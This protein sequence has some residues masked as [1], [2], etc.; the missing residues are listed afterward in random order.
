MYNIPKNGTYAGV[1]MNQEVHNE[2]WI[3]YTMWLKLAESFE[4][5]FEYFCFILNISH[6]VQEN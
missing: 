4:S 5:L 2:A 6:F 1:G 3:L